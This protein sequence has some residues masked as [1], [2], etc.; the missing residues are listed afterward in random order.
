MNPI[1]LTIT[2]TPKKYEIAWEPNLDIQGVLEKVYFIYHPKDTH[3]D[4][5]V[6]YYGYGVDEYLGYMIIMVNNQF[7][8]VQAGEYWFISVNNNDL[9]IGIDS[10][11]LSAGASL[12]LNYKK[13]DPQLHKDTHVAAMYAYHTSK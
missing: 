11:I 13:Y 3:F 1:T 8:N 4:F 6:Q 12:N 5:A 9:K 2:G 10:Y 7:Q